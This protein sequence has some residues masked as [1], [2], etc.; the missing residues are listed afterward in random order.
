M[1]YDEVLNNFQK[2]KES[3]INYLSPYG[4][5]H[6]KEYGEYTIKDINIKKFS[7]YEFKGY[8]MMLILDGHGTVRLNNQV[9]P[10]S[11][12]NMIIFNADQAQIISNGHWSVCYMILEGDYVHKMMVTLLKGKQ[13][14]RFNNLCYMRNLFDQVYK[15]MIKINDVY[16]SLNTCSY[17]LKLL[18]EIEKNNVYKED[19][20]SF[21]IKVLNYIEKHFT[22]DIS[23][24]SIAEHFGY[25]RDYLIKKFKKIVHETPHNY[26]LSRRITYAKDLLDKREL[27][28]K[29]ISKETGFNSESNFCVAF[30]RMTKTT[31]KEYQKLSLERKVKRYEERNRK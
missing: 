7:K 18:S 20:N 15:S 29:E 3:K 30:K 11:V 13:V 8:Q 6:V 12:G 16:S 10:L 1:I 28:I 14:F 31:P 22:E 19:N 26:I 23:V 4:L 24:D 21:E 17:V 5:I 2:K 25:S 27:S 9:I